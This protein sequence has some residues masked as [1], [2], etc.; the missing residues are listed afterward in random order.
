MSKDRVNI[1]FGMK[2]P[3]F[4]GQ[5]SSI[6]FHVSYSSDA[7]DGES[8]D[9]TFDRV[10]HIVEVESEKS[11]DGIIQARKEKSKEESEEEENEEEGGPEYGHF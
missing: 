7:K 10:R 11:Y 2:V 3:G 8:V 4:E 6:D 5:F 1:S 9:D